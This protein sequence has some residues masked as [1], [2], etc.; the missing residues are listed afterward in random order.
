MDLTGLEGVVLE[1]SEASRGEMTQVKTL[2]L[3]VAVKVCSSPLLAWTYSL[4]VD[5]R[6][7]PLW[8]VTVNIHSAFEVNEGV[9]RHG[10]GARC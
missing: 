4:L 1:M 6:V 10:P 3:G 5:W 9:C 2:E 8:G 7:L